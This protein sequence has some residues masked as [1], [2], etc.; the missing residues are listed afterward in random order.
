MTRLCTQAHAF[1]PSEITEHMRCSECQRSTT[2]I[3]RRVRDALERSEYHS[4]RVGR[5]HWS[6]G[7]IQMRCV[8]DS[9]GSFAKGSF[10]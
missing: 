6:N 2:A 1:V 4:V 7:A 5:L 9:L 10:S 3:L 8:L